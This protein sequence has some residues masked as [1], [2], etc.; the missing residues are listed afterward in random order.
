M[1]SYRNNSTSPT[2]PEEYPRD[3]TEPVIGLAF[4]TPERRKG[5]LAD[6]VDTLKQKKLGELTKT[7]QDGERNFSSCHVCFICF[8]AKSGTNLSFQLYLIFRSDLEATHCR[9]SLTWQ[10]RL[11]FYW[12]TTLLD[13]RDFIWRALREIYWLTPFRN[14][15]S[16]CD[17]AYHPSV[18]LEA[19]KLRKFKF[20]VELLQCKVKYLRGELHH[21]SIM[22]FSSRGWES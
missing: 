6:V 2:K 13:P 4:G 7:E 21:S 8:S 5:S 11:L 20:F 3:R 18:Y 12:K 1:Y 19:I 9:N 15:T 14:I 10:L 22:N 17:R 16:T